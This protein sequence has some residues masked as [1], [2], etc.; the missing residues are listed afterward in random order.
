MG[1]LIH[2]DELKSEKAMWYVEDHYYDVY[3]RK[4]VFKWPNVTFPFFHPIHNSK[5]TKNRTLGVQ[6][7]RFIQR[8]IDDLVIYDLEVKS[9]RHF[10]GDTSKWE[11]SY[12]IDNRWFRFFFE[13]KE[14]SFLFKTAFS[15]IISPI[16]DWHPD[17]PEHQKVFKELYPEKYNA[18]TSDDS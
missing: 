14:S 13:S 1:Q 11:H 2:V 17:Y 7:R 4:H 5:F 8:S 9:Y 3:G 18:K 15:D 12:E 10:Y 6:I 16:T